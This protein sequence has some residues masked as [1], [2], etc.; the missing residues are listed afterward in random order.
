MNPYIQII[1]PNVC[2]LSVFGLIVGSVVCGAV[3]LV[4]PIM[5]LYAAITSFLICSSGNVINDYFDFEID[6]INKPNRPIPSGR[7]SRKNVVFYFIILGLSGLGFA[8]FVSFPFFIIALF[9][10][11]VLTAYASNLKRT[12]LVGNF[13][14]S[15]LAVSSVFASG[16]IVNS[17][18]FSMPLLLL[19]IISFFGTMSREIFKDI[20]DVKGDKTVGAKT[21]PIVI[22]APK[23]KLI[24]ILFL[25][26]AC[27][28]LTI[29]LYQ[30]I[31]SYYL[32]GVI[33][34]ILFSIF[35]IIQAKPSK[36]QKLIKI[37]MISVLLAFL[38]ENLQ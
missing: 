10:F 23:S 34:A 24:A 27:L 37:A 1:R 22:G 4:K 30:K 21:L 26:I 20:E 3:W 33:P 31:L 15:Y 17:F 32:I 19:I 7:I 29:P 8:Y 5:M 12:L 28:L 35:A 38:I 14:V 16:F 36:S 6:K 13:T 18:Q 25:A 2:L 9:N 11:F